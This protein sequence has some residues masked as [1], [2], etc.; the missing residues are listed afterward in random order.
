MG[1]ERL[2]AQLDATVLDV[3]TRDVGG[4]YELLAID[5]NH[6]E[7]WRFL[8]MNNQSIGAVHV[9]AVPRQCETVRHAI[10]WRASQDINQDWFPSQLTLRRCM[11]N[12][13]QF[14]QGDIWLQRVTSIL[15]TPNLSTVRF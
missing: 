8:K 6:G 12:P 3:E 5:M 13:D 2:V 4:R 11:K 1:G 15:P 9:E 10:N 7:P 14:Q